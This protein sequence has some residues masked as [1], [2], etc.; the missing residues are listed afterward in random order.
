MPAVPFPFNRKAMSCVSWALVC[1]GEG[2]NIYISNLWVYCDSFSTARTQAHRKKERFFLYFWSW[3]ANPSTIGTSVPVQF[4]IVRVLAYNKG[5]LH[6][7]FHRMNHVQYTPSGSLDTWSFS[8]SPPAQL[9]PSSTGD[10]SYGGPLA[11]LADN[12]A[13]GIPFLHA[14]QELPAEAEDLCP[15]PNRFVHDP[16]P[17]EGSQ[18]FSSLAL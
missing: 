17:R 12:I 4:I 3:L 16:L 18:Q 7:N 1:V 2:E 10:L 8:V 9:I 5:M 15:F 13:E 11:W 14:C 6:T